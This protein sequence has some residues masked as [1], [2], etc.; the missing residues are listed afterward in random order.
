MADIA[1]S[2]EIKWSNVIN[3]GMAA[4]SF[5][6]VGSIVAGVWFIAGFGTM[7]INYLMGNGT[8]GLGD[9]IDEWAGGPIIK[10]YDGI[11]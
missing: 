5:T 3:T 6:G 7:G 4:A 10:M 8:V 1:M 2:G 9:M 11:Y